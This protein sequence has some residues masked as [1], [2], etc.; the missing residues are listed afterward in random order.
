MANVVTW[1]DTLDGNGSP[2]SRDQSSCWYTLVNEHQVERVE[3]AG[4]LP[5]RLDPRDD[6]RL[7][8]ILA[9]QPRRVDAD[10]N[11]GADGAQFVG[12]LFEQFFDVGQD[13]DPT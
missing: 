12:R 1:P 13:H 8:A 9:F 7:L 10:R 3:V 2:R 4:L 6:H 5:H 11:F